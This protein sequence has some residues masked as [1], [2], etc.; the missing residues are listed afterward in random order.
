MTPAVLAGIAVLVAATAV[1]A[2][3][4]VT[5][6]FESATLGA[7]PEGFTSAHTGAGPPGSWLVENDP[8]AP[9][10]SRV[11][12]QRS[13]DETRGRFP[14]C[15]FEGLSVADG[16]FRVKFKPLAG[17]VDQAAGII[18]R[19]RDADNYYVVRA[20]ALESNVVLYK[21]Q[22]GKRSDLKPVGSS[23]LAY[24]KNTTV[25]PQ[26]WQELTVEVRGTLFKVFLGGEHL[27]DVEDATFREP[28]KV[29]VW[30]KADS[31]TAFDDLSIAPGLDR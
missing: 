13:T 25:A 19:V 1:A 28:G 21:V 8:G 26:Q 9:S 23:L 22:D 2:Q 31:V 12:V 17:T 30:T 11:L 16:T 18:W 5:F 27:F 10:G 14:I 29:G 4:T 3:T 7:L 15:F 24:G 20:N 6:D